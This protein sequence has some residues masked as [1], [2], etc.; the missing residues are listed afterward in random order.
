M[1]ECSYA[2]TTFIG[3]GRAYAVSRDYVCH[4]TSYKYNDSIVKIIGCKF[5]T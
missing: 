3:H 5:V 2:Y 1:L 4:L